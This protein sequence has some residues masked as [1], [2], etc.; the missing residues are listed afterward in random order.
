V[1]AVRSES[2]LADGISDE[3]LQRKVFGNAIHNGAETPNDP[4]QAGRA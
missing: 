4:A 1:N 2:D 3:S